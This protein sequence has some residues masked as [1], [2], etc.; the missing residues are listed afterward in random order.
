MPE[1]QFY[2]T[3]LP[4]IQPTISVLSTPPFQAAGAP[5]DQVDGQ[6]LPH[7]GVNKVFGSWDTLIFP[8]KNL[9]SPGNLLSGKWGN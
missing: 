4:V 3:Q 5:A 2:P 6:L 7:Y 9:E 8:F 1:Y